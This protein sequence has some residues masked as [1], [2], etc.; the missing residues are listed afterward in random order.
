ML[1]G[2]WV[3]QSRARALAFL[4]AIAGCAES[5][6]HGAGGGRSAP[7]VGD[8]LDRLRRAQCESIWACPL[9]D[10]GSLAQTEAGFKAGAQ[11]V[12]GCIELLGHPFDPNRR[13]LEEKGETGDVVVDV[14]DLEACEAEL[15][16]CVHDR[17]TSSS[18]CDG[19]L[20]G[21]LGEGASCSRTEECGEGLR[22]DTENGRCPGSCRAKSAEGG[23]CTVTKD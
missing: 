19:F 16:S 4:C 17:F 2:M 18:A 22:C 7:S 1:S 3:R 20:E 11:S 14:E 13:D 15:R 9:P 10:D 8:A 5:E 12:E 23:A 6:Q 21:L